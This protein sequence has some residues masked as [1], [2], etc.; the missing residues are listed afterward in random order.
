MMSLKKYLQRHFKSKLDQSPIRENLQA[1]N[2]SHLIPV[3]KPISDDGCSIWDVTMI[4]P[5][6]T[7]YQNGRYCATIQLTFD[8]SCV[9]PI[10]QWKNPPFACN[11]DEKGKTCLKILRVVKDRLRRRYQIEHFVSTL[12]DEIFYNLGRD[13]VNNKKRMKL[14]S[15][16]LSEFMYQASLYNELY[17]KGAVATHYQLP[18]MLITQYQ[19]HLNVIMHTI[20]NVYNVPND[21]IKSILIPFYGSATEYTGLSGIEDIELLDDQKTDNHEDMADIKHAGDDVL[22]HVADP[23]C[24][25]S[26][27]IF[28]INAKSIMNMSHVRKTIGKT[29]PRSWIEGYHLIHTRTNKVLKDKDLVSK[30]DFS[31]GASNIRVDNVIVISSTVR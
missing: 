27:G 10:I 3:L 31:S 2:K 17:A 7:P 6:N 21:L 22:I 16:N 28:T 14:L 12:Y 11:I 4:G 18:Q 25:M 1:W 23:R 8:A 26:N 19:Q 15:S 30:Y 13:N 20:N 9:L 29:L 5:P 24:I